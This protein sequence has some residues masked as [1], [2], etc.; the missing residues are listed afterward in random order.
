MHILHGISFT[1]FILL[2]F[3]CRD[4]RLCFGY[5]TTLYYRFA[6]IGAY[7]DTRQRTC[8]AG[9]GTRGVQCQGSGGTFGLRFFLEHWESSLEEQGLEAAHAAGYIIEL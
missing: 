9:T 3:I 6:T 2:L 5:G 7:S 4:L 8:L 1:F